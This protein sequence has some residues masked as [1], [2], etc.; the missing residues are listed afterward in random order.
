VDDEVGSIN[1]GGEVSGHLS[2]DWLVLQVNPWTWA[3]PSSTSR[4]G[5]M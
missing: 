2:K 1:K 5:L 4:S 3:A